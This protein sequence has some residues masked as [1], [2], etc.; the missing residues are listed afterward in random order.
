MY[1]ER[2]SS[3][4]EGE[5]YQQAFA[6]L[7][8]LT[9]TWLSDYDKSVERRTKEELEE[10]ALLADL[11]SDPSVVIVEIP[12][13]R[14][15]FPGQHAYQ[16]EVIAEL[17]SLDRSPYRGEADS[18]LSSNAEQFRSQFAIEL[19]SVSS[20]SALESREVYRILLDRGWVHES[21]SSAGIR[22]FLRNPN[23]K[24]EIA[25]LRPALN[26]TFEATAEAQEF[27]DQ[28]YKAARE[29]FSRSKARVRALF[30]SDKQDWVR[31]FLSQD[32]S[33]SE[34]KQLVTENPEAARRLISEAFPFCWHRFTT[35]ESHPL[36]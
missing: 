10:K 20:D 1:V 2:L 13:P 23:C 34:A 12:G 31:R 28:A 22:T 19:L 15:D 18:V 6:N 36:R 25:K 4:L 16:Q 33:Q 24:G 3:W 11:A 29:N 30:A 7:L 21:T 26:P 9:R 17:P 14:E 32:F 5:E 35:G 8:I 27:L